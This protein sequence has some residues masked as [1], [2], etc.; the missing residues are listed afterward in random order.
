MGIYYSYPVNGAQK[1][2]SVI[3]N[4]SKPF[5]PNYI[6]LGNDWKSEEKHFATRAEIIHD[7]DNRILNWHG[8]NGFTFR[9]HSI[10]LCIP[11][12]LPRID[13]ANNDCVACCSMP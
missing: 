2:I 10:H 1:M 11:S 7:W 5:I 6:E 9:F 8:N 4:N 3:K 12:V 13:A